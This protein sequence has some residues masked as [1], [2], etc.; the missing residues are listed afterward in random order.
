MKEN[1]NKW[2]KF[3][4]ACV[5]CIGTITLLALAIQALTN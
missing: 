4:I 2:Y 1:G 5:I 3:V